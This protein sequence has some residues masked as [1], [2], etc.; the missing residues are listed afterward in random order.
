[1]TALTDLA[2]ERAGFAVSQYNG[3]KHWV[4]TGRGIHADYWPTVGKFQ[5]Y[6]NVFHAS[7][8]DFIQAAQ[9]GRY[10]KP[11]TLSQ[12]KYC[13]A[14]IYWAKSARGKWIPLDSDGASH[15]AHC[16]RSS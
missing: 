16:R 13:G 1:M 11:D 4:L 15:I 9:A 8:E 14:S 3:G 2:F 7:V 10:T 12:C 6:G 5:V